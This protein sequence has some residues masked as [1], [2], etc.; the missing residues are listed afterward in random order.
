M[1]IFSLY[2]KQEQHMGVKGFTQFIMEELIHNSGDLVDQEF[3][4]L[5]EEIQKAH[6]IFLCGK[7]RSGLAIQAFANRLMHLGFSV[8]QIGEITSPHSVAGDLLIIGSGSGE[9]ESLIALAGKAKQKG[10][11]VALL[12]M[13]RRSTIGRMA[14]L[15]VELPG[16]SPK[17]IGMQPTAVSIQPMGSIFEQMM[18]LSCDG[19]VLQFMEQMHQTSDEM[20]GR[21]ADLE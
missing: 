9:T 1:K 19:M 3:E 8:S 2:G 4:I 13:N 12:T 6:H 5:L 7:G 18:L 15:C 10:V 20:F 16:A 14:D 11:K 17:T 21:H